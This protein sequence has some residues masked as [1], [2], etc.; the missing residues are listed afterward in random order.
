[1]ASSGRARWESGN[2]SELRRRWDDG[3]SVETIAARF[4]VPK[5][6]IYSRAR[7]LNLTLRARRWT[8]SETRYIRAHVAELVD[9][10]ALDL[11]RSPGAIEN[12]I[13]RMLTKKD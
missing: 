6:V 8:P 1:M 5:V 4:G 9:K 11:I 10:L 7:K 2:D 13:M 3:E 12:R